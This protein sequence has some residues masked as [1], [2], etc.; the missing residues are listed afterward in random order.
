M[1]TRAGLAAQNS[2]TPFWGLRCL[3][4]ME[5][6]PEDDIYESRTR[7]E[8]GVA[9]HRATLRLA[10]QPRGRDFDVPAEPTPPGAGDA[11]TVVLP[12]REGVRF[13]AWPR[14]RRVAAVTLVVL[15]SGVSIRQLRRASSHDRVRAGATTR[16]AAS[17]PSVRRGPALIVAHRRAKT[18]P[19]RGVG[20]QR[21]SAHGHL[22]PTKQASVAS[23]TPASS[24]RANP[25][26]AA[27]PQPEGDVT[28][29]DGIPAVDNAPA[30]ARVETPSPAPRRRPPCLP[31]TLGC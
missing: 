13:P 14:T 11:V 17:A 30:P 26:R 9:D 5:T 19:W 25:G 27:S 7:S 20:R 12:A 10:D 28:R 18:S 15:G 1:W 8:H 21:G 23:R 4:G 6:L 22:G 2:L 3:K 16:H 29:A 31:G 24:V